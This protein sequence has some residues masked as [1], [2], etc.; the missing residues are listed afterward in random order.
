MIWAGGN[1]LGDVALAL[2]S[3]TVANDLFSVFWDMFGEPQFTGSLLPRPADLSGLGTSKIGI[4]NQNLSIKDI[5]GQ[6]SRGAVSSPGMKL[7]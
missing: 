4:P 3:H 5:L 2:L 6:S 1:L 7:P